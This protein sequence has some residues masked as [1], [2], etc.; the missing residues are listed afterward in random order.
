MTII[1]DHDVRLSTTLMFT[2][3]AY[4]ENEVIFI[5]VAKGSA[6]VMWLS[7]EYI[8]DIE[9]NENNLTSGDVRIPKRINSY[10]EAIILVSANISN[11]T[12]ILASKLKINVSEYPNP[13]VTCCVSVDGLSKETISFKALTGMYWFVV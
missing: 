8:G 9:G 3:F 1:S 6:S 12:R 13:S 5:C 7:D 4:P 11:G 2:E 10:T